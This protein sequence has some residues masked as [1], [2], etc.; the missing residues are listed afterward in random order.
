MYS[1][2]QLDLHPRII[3]ALNK[4][5]VRS[6]RDV[7]HVSAP[8]LQRLTSL[9]A[10]DVCHLLTAAALH[11]RPRR[12]LPVLRAEETGATLSLG[13]PLLDGLLRGG[14]PVGGVTELSGE[15]GAGK[16]QLALQLCLSAQY[17][18]R[19]GGLD[20]GAV[21]VCTEDAFPGKRLRQLITEQPRLRP[22]V[23]AGVTAGRR[24]GDHVYVEHAPDLA[25]LRLCL[26]RRVALLL[27]RRLV[28]FVAVDS[29]AALF[30]AELDP[31]Q[32][33]ERSRELLALSGVLRHLCQHYNP[34]VLCINQVSDIFGDD[35]EH[36]GPSGSNVRPALGLAWANQVT[37]R[38]TMRRLGRT[39][40]RDGR[41]SVL[42]RLE[43][44][45]A[46]HL[47]RAGRHAA[48]WK[49][50]VRGLEDDP[51]RPDVDL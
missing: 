24:F 44:V 50:G 14:L 17:P 35:Q 40:S 47:P 34:A 6:V 22:D 3:G 21:F 2:R 19:H 18:A 31:S 36:T 45:F 23:P 7:L 8:D 29:V 12:P 5:G 27:A 11:C 26:R 46:P 15:S 13:C 32:W 48:V 16:T 20:S 1:L 9:S 41:D 4:A 28:R 51:D 39:V 37:V 33:A 42:R 38:L 10:G 49:E 30:R 43:V 25:S